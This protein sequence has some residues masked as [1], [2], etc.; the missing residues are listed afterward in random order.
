MR[1]PLIDSLTHSINH[2]VEPDNNQLLDHLITHINQIHASLT[3]TLRP[4]SVARQ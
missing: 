1:I 4:S 2:L 3:L